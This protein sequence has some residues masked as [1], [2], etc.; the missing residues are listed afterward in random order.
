MKYRSNMADRERG[1]VDKLRPFRPGL[2]V[3]TCEVHICTTCT[4]L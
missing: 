3:L 1:A 4:L 2:E